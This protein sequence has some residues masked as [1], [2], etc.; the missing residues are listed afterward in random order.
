M[1]I[2]A[3]N[4]WAFVLRGIVAILFGLLTAL[5][6]ELALLTLVFMFGFY[7]LTDGVFN[8]IAAFRRNAAQKAQEPWWVFAIQ[9]VLGLAAGVLTLFMPG[10]TAIALLFLIAGWATLSG[11]MSIV[12]AIRLRRQIRGEWLLVLSGILSIAFGVLTAI[13]PGAGALAVVL[14]I[15]AYSFVMGIL[16]ILLGFRLRKW[17]HERGEQLPPRFPAVAPSN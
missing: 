14:W 8:L 9:G 7:A 10:I 3:G 1:L 6:P 17:Q 4:W 15:G 12:A 11:V 5:L 13:F 16:L 2:I